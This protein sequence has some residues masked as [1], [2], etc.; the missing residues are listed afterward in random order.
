MVFVL[1]AHSII[2]VVCAFQDSF[3]MNNSMINLILTA[4]FPLRGFFFISEQ[5]SVVLENA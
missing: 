4:S 1:N 5:N 2:A 3:N